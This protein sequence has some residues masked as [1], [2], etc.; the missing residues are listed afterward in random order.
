MENMKLNTPFQLVVH[1]P[2]TEAGLQA[3]RQRVSDVHADYVI[4]SINHLKAPA[5]QKLELLQAV[6]DTINGTYDPMQ[7]QSKSISS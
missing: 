1:T 7:K 3:L 2:K 4:T 6:I 5:K